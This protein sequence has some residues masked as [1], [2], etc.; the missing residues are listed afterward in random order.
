MNPARTFTEL[1]R[2]YGQ[3]VELYY[4]GEPAGV[5]CRAF[6]QPI[7]ERKEQELPSPLGR[8][9]QDKWLYLGDPKMPLN[10]PEKGYVLWQ[11]KQYR[12]LNA[13]PVYLGKQVNHWRGILQ[14]IDRPDAC[15]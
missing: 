3:E 4:S 10:S 6:V 8:V 14:M 11:G 7:L 15:S 13:H 9:R 12:V 5:P 2:R 1:L